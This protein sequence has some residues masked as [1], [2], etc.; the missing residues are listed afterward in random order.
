MSNKIG[1][2]IFFI[3]YTHIY[4]ESKITILK[5][6]LLNRGSQRGSWEEK[7]LLW[8][9]GGPRGD[10]WVAQQSLSQRQA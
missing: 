1:K 3:I 6:S 5:I 8:L 10:G 7:G 9:P 4:I 2:I